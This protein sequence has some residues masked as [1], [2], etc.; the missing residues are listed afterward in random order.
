[1]LDDGA[2]QLENT[3]AGSICVLCYHS[4]VGLLLHMMK[5][6]TTAAFCYACVIRSQKFATGV[7]TQNPFLP[8]QSRVLL[9]TRR[10]PVYIRDG[11]DKN[12][13]TNFR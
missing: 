1:M 10:K 12:P 9:S 7:E 11:E 8:L 5:I 3:Y 2:K 4:S 13:S 6:E